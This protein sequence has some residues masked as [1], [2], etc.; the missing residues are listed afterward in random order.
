MHIDH[1][2]TSSAFGVILVC[3]GGLGINISV[4]YPASVLA[5]NIVFTS[6]AVG[7]LV[8][9]QRRSKRL[10]GG[11]DY[12]GV[13]Y[14]NISAMIAESA[15]INVLLQT[16]ALIAVF[17]RGP[18]SFIFTVNLLGQTQLSAIESAIAF[19]NPLWTVDV[20][21]FE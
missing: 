20:N 13:L 8:Y 5:T 9:H 7:R 6:L 15:G 18:M 3:E 21:I 1:S 17:S 10:M 12:D 4:G 2:S 19:K 16:L 11:S 14:T